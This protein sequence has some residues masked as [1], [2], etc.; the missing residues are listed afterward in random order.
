VHPSL[1]GVM[2]N[3]NGEV[4]I[5]HGFRSGSVA[6]EMRAE[7]RMRFNLLLVF[8]LIPRGLPITPGKP[9]LVDFKTRGLC[10]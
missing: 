10:D 6:K 2:R 9:I 1:A 3:S 4:L 5:N 8:G 7:N